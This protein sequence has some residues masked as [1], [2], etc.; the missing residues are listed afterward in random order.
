MREHDAYPKHATPEQAEAFKQTGE[1]SLDEL[2][3][4]LRAN[5]DDSAV[6]DAPQPGSE[7]VEPTAEPAAGQSERTAMAPAQA[8]PT[9]PVDL[10]IITDAG[11]DDAEALLALKNLE[12]R[13]KNK[14]RK[15]RAKMA[16]AIAAVA[17]VGGFFVLRGMLSKPESEESHEPQV[18]YVE[19][20]DFSTTIQGSG[21]LKPNDSVVVTPE[22]DGIIE[23]VRVAKDQ[24]VKEGDVLFTIRS[25]DL[26]KE[27]SAAAQVVSDRQAD[28]SKAYEALNKAQA[29]YDEA[30]AT[31][32]KDVAAWERALAKELAPTESAVNK[33]NDS[34]DK[35]A[36]AL[37]ETEAAAQAVKESYTAVT[38]AAGAAGDAADAAQSA[39][40]R[41]SSASLP[42][43]VRAAAGEL[44]AVADDVEDARDRLLRAIEDNRC[45]KRTDEFELQRS[46]E[47]AELSLRSAKD[48][49]D[50]TSEELNSAYGQLS[51]LVPQFPD[52]Y[53]AGIAD[54]QANIETAESELAT[55]QKSYAETTEEVSKLT[56]TAPKAGTLVSMDAVVGAST[57]AKTD[58]GSLAQIADISKM[59]VSI[60][61]SEIDISTISVGQ[62]ATCTFSAV[63]DLT[64]EAKVVSVASIASSSGEGSG[65]GAAS[66]T[67]ELVID[68]PDGRL[69]PG[70]TTTV[71]ILTQDVPNALVVPSMAI[72]ED[73]G[74]TY[75]SYVLDEET[76]QTELRAVTVGE[77]NASEAVI[78]EGLSEGD[79]ILQV[80]DA[81]AG[82]AETPEAEA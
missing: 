73:G 20:A 65:G 28:V 14:K 1:M 82:A 5:A 66:F 49:V 16:A 60:E 81:G 31:Y 13:R 15:Q 2:S 26:D 77:R 80:G 48:V 67:V 18:T 37:A 64:A 71:T 53:A 70:M 47:A 50:A 59:R 27:I 46:A 41:L 75:V 68:K 30:W 43:D 3:D 58:T 7:P 11:G 8:T 55:A 23:T 22:V 51:G 39:A 35:A 34:L 45:P 33:A 19:R 79:P 9:A 57:G 29:T 76:L 10:P 32:E 4:A 61:V 74:K 52:S 69:K 12:Q 38:D 54:A 17:L 25:K 36:A 21:A 40:N 72:V 62:R 56:I 78:E 24:E 44:S 63:P 42:E 6:Q